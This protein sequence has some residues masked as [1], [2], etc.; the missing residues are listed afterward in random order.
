MGLSLIIWQFSQHIYMKSRLNKI[1]YYAINFL[2]IIFISKH[3]LLWTNVICMDA[4]EL[5]GTWSKRPPPRPKKYKMKKFLPTVGFEPTALIL[6][7][8]TTIAWDCLRTMF[9]SDLYTNVYVLYI[10]ISSRH[11]DIKDNLFCPLHALHCSN[12]EE[13]STLLKQQKNAEV[14][15]FVFNIENKTK[16]TTWLKTR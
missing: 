9:E 6:A 7:P 10:G 11:C 4:V 12:S 8:P 15:C 3:L 14:L 1:L 2:N 13:I 16:L 5:Q